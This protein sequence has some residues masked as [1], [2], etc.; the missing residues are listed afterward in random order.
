MNHY[1]KELINK[2]YNTSE[3]SIN[4]FVHGY[5]SNLI[6]GIGLAFCIEQ[7]KYLHLPLPLL[8][9][10]I[11]LG[12]QAYQYKLNIKNFVKDLFQQK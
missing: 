12:Y 3:H 5:M 7:D 6:R 10:S 1:S 8:C 4:L 9:P 11:Y 2:I